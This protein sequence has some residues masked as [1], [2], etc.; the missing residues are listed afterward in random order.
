MSK[1][2]PG[3]PKESNFYGNR[4][5][6]VPNTYVIG[7]AMRKRGR[8]A[9]ISASS[10]RNYST[11]RA[12]APEVNITKKLKDL[13]QRSKANPNIPIDRDLYKLVCDIDLLRVAYDRLKSKPG[14]MTP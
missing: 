6:V 12:T 9:A 11:G 4:A 7:N 2:I 13:Y 5:T 14:Q 3:L 1:I 8:V 10:I